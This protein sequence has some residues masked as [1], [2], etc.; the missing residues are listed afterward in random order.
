MKILFLDLDTLRADHLGCYDYHRNTSPNIDSIAEDGVRFNNYYCS[1]APCLPSRTALMSGRFGIHTGVVNHGGL[2][3]D[4]RLMGAERC[5]RDILAEE[6][7]PAFLRKQGFRTISISPFAERHSCWNFYAGFTEMYNTGKRGRESAE[8]I[9]PLALDWIKRNKDKDNWFLHVNYWDPHTPY[10]APKEFGN[11]FEDDPIPQ[12]ITEDVFK[13]HWKNKVGPHGAREINLF[14]SNSYPD[15]PRYKTELKNLSDVKDCFDGYDC[16]I[17]H[18]DNNIG[19]ILDMLKEEGMYND[20]AII[21]TADHGEAIGELGIYGEHSVADYSTT[22]IP[23]IIKWPGA[24]KGY[25]DEGL[26][27]NLD[28]APTLAEIFQQEKLSS[29]D[30]QSYAQSIFNRTDTGRDDLILGQCSHVCQRSVRFNNLLYIRTYHDGFHLFPKEMLFDIKK[31]PYEQHDVA[32]LN[33]DVCK[34]ATYRL[35]NWHDHMMMTMKYD[36]DPLWTV[37]KEGGPFHAKGELKKYCERLKKTDRGFAV[38]EL[39]RRHPKEFI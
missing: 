14:D 28:L 9:T 35:T 20:L 2:A 10:R 12:W 36:V 8:E 3:A 29:W 32:K 15:F 18:M 30:G 17:R 23:M 13:D 38:E 1:D 26:H 5:A 11:P 4:F 27:Y 6:S 16:G 33:L 25:V 34:E 22:H 19:Q 24:Q 21:V 7:L 37:I 39:K 31:D